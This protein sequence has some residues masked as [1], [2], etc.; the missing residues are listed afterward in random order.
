MKKEI[1]KIAIANRGE[2]A[3]RLISTFQEMGI[4]PILLYSA[5]DQNNLAYRM[6]P[7]KVCIGPAN[8]SQSYLNINSCIE[9]ALSLGADAIHPG[10]G[11][12]SENPGLAK[13]CEENNIIFIGPSP[14]CLEIF[15]DKVRARE[16][17]INCGLPVLPAYTGS[18]SNQELLLKEVCKMGFPVMI[19]S[20]GGGGGRGLRIVHSKEEWKE[21]FLS[22]KRE[23]KN[24]FGSEN[25]FIEKYLADARHIEVQV[26]GDA[27]GQVFHLLD[28]D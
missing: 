9:G 26:F 17:A 18:T 22:A 24:A 7:E 28:R 20:T 19:K 11:F 5:Q 23:T 2:I 21:A 10:Y 4:H 15:G 1:K 25:L 16:L 3:V 14:K 12:L 6:S 13:T 8:I 27:S